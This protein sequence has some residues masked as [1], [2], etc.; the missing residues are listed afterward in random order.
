M[1]RNGSRKQY[2]I[3]RIRMG[4]LRETGWDIK[5]VCMSTRF[6]L[7]MKTDQLETYMREFEAGQHV[8]PLVTQ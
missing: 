4:L 3:L 1:T 2:L 6:L 7:R 5:A 8:V